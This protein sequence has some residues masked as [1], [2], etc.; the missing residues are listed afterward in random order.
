MF[1]IKIFTITIAS[2]LKLMETRVFGTFSQKPTLSVS[3]PPGKLDP[4][5]GAGQGGAG[6][7]I[8]GGGSNIP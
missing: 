7:V 2:S 5:V 6:R 3:I 4:A 1:I 8:R